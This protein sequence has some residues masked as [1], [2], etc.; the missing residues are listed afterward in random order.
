MTITFF[1]ITV[2]SQTEALA[3]GKQAVESRLAACAN[4]FGMQSVFPWKNQ[5]AEEHEYVLVLKTMPDIAS[6]LQTFISTIHSYSVPC[7]LSWDVEV[8]ESYGKWVAENTSPI[9]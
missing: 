5:I 2:G 8:N 9:P 6:S 7:I 4:V 3:I 1:Y